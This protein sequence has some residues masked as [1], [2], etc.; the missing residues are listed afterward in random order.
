M[1]R[2]VIGGV[3]AYLPARVLTNDELSRRLDTSDAWIRERT[4]I[5]E[6]HI[7]ADGELTSDLA[8]AAARQALERA[9]VPARGIDLVLLATST[10][11]NT[12]PAT[13]TAVQRKLGVPPGMAFDLQAVCAGFVYALAVADNFIRL[14]Q[15]RTALV[16]GAE[17]FSR[18]LDWQD[19]STC[20]LFGDGAGAVV[21]RGEAQPGLASDRGILA[22]RLS[23]DGRHYLDLHVDGGASSTGTVGHLRMNGREVFRR[24]VAELVGSA[25]QVL[26][27]GGFTAA[28]VDWVVPHQA[29]QRIIDAVARRL[30][31]G[32]ERVV[33]T[34][35]RHANTSAASIPLALAQAVA[36]G[37]LGAGHLVVMN[38]MGGGFAWG[39][40]LARW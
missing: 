37:R 19:R 14:G 34:V 4:G 33:S 24:A 30:D 18:I 11:D 20:V 23:A 21:L 13:A 35:A 5:G 40:A 17:T 8:V 22:T 39:A 29:N 26:A 12:F 32:P 25:E 9:D 16:I 38:A 1:I 6:R 27:D 10:P 15:A 36:D 28:D 3:G 2:S 7:V 31:I